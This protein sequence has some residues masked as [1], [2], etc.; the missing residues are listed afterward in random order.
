[1]SSHDSPRPDRCTIPLAVIIEE[2][3]RGYEPPIVLMQAFIDT[4]TL[5]SF[6]QSYAQLPLKMQRQI[7]AHAAINV[8]NFDTIISLL[9][10]A[11]DYAE[12]WVAFKEWTLRQP[13]SAEELAKSRPPTIASADLAAKLE[14]FSEQGAM[15]GRLRVDLMRATS[16]DERE[17]ITRLIAYAEQAFAEENHG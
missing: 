1:M 10:E 9:R 7:C 2:H 5:G 14:R 13:W 17:E 8:A 12:G 16:D 4:T 6:D 3:Q 11:G 15:L